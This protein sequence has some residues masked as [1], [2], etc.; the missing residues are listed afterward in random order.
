MRENGTPAKI[1]VI[2]LTEYAKISF[3]TSI[4]TSKGLAEI[5]P[6]KMAITPPTHAIHIDE[7]T[8]LLVLSISKAPQ[9]FAHI[10]VAPTERHIK[11]VKIKL[12]I[13]DVAPTA[14]NAISPEYFPTTIWSAV[15]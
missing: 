5:T 13:V 4:N 15:L 2:Y 7:C 3:G 6:I 14:A 8:V 10:T 11:R 1:M 9:Y 12:V